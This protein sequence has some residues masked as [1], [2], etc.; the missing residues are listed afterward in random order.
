M[1]YQ[2]TLADLKGPKGKYNLHC[3]KVQ[4]GNDPEKRESLSKN[5]GGKN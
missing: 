3:G 2:N 4:K 1:I 5:R